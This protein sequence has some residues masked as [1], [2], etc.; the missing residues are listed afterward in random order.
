MRCPHKKEPGHDFGLL[1]V[2][3][4]RIEGGARGGRRADGGG[5][6]DL[7]AGQ[8]HRFGNLGHRRAEVEHLSDTGGA[9]PIGQVV[10]VIVRDDLLGDP[11]DAAFAV[12]GGGVQ[13]DQGGKTGQTGVTTGKNSALAVAD[14]DGA[15]CVADGLDRL[16][17]AVF[18]DRFGEFG[19]HDGIDGVTSVGF[20]LSLDR[21]Q[22]DQF[23]VCGGGDRWCLRSWCSLS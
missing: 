2:E 15:V 3:L 17:Y 4:T 21:V 20:D 1:E 12:A 5:G 6:F 23:R 13:C 16:E 11:L 7:G 8:A 19:E 9:L 14:P 22:I 18:A 10:A